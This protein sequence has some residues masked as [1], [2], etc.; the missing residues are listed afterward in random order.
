MSIESDRNRLGVEGFFS[1]PCVMEGR[2]QLDPKLFAHH[3]HGALGWLAS[4]KNQITSSVLGKMKN[5]VVS[6]DQN[7]RRRIPLDHLL[8]KA[9]VRDRRTRLRAEHSTLVPGSVPR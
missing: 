7:T 6:A 1:F 4:G 9:T 3:L 5:L 2:L 8:M